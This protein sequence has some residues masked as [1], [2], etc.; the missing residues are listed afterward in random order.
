MKNGKLGLSTN[1]LDGVDFLVAYSVFYVKIIKRIRSLYMSWNGVP[2]M[3]GRH[4][5][6]VPS[7]F[8]A[9]SQNKTEGK[10][11]DPQ[12][13]NNVPLRPSTPSSSSKIIATD[14]FELEGSLRMRQPFFSKFFGIF[15]CLSNFIIIF[16][17]GFLLYF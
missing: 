13:L 2:C 15:F 14:Y 9:K 12:S 6:Y 8:I 7:V 16:F 10:P 4:D 5:R 17:Y 11:E 1:I 3:V